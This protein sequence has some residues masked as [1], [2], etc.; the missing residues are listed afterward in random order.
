MILEEQL[1]FLQNFFKYHWLPRCLPIGQFNKI[2]HML[3]YDYQN[4]SR[5]I[6]FIMVEQKRLNA[7]EFFE[8]CKII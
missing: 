2:L 5:S 4:N 1:E 3:L 8:F 6:N 7:K